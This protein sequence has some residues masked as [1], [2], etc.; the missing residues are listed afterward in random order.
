MAEPRMKRKFVLVKLDETRNWEHGDP[1]ILA[2]AGR[3]FGRYV[4]DLSVGVHCC[5]LTRSYELHFVE[6]QWEGTG[7]EL[8]DADRAAVQDYLV[9][10]D[11]ET[12]AVIYVHCHVVDGLPVLDPQ[13][14]EFFPPKGTTG[15]VIELGAVEQDEDE[16]SD[17]D[18]LE[19]ML[20]YVRTRGF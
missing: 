1:A 19:G 18:A 8:S 14:G 15:A 13:Q 9:D 2:M 17:A 20:E 7:E 12:A 3:I 10:G 5:E 16:V 11:R 6:S 4:A